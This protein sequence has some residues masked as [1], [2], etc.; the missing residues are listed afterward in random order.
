MKNLLALAAGFLCLQAA[1]AAVVYNT[2]STNAGTTGNYVLT[3]TENAGALD[4]HLTVNPWN[5]EALGLFV[6]LGDI[7]V[8][9]VSLSNVNPV[10]KVSVFATDTSSLDC[11]EGCNLNGTGLTNEW[12][13]IFRLG[14]QGFDGIKTFSFTATSN[15][16]SF[17]ED[18]LGTVG[19]RAQQ[20]CKDAGETLPTCSPQDSDK[21]WGTG[22]VLEEVN[23]PEPGVTGLLGL[24]AIA[25]G[26]AGAARRRK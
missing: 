15:L 9:A 24:G 26:F 8:G 11:G 25:L 7:D 16:V 23:V 22:R 19:I 5:A 1:N 21:A 12:E 20:L 10:E 6:D 18:M 2:W 17:T 3:V 4:F 13:L 14:A